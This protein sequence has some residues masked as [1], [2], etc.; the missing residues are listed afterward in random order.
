M[1]GLAVGRAA[2][3]LVLC[4]AVLLV[5]SVGGYLAAIPHAARTVIKC[6]LPLVLLL[7]TCACARFERLRPWKPVSIALLAASC[8]FLVAWVLSDR[9]LADEPTGNLDTGSGSDVMS[10]L[11]ALS[12]QGRTLVV[13]THDLHLARRA[14]RVV[15]IR[16]GVIVSDA[17]AGG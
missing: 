12:E 10:L 11:G 4:G 1:R 16:D 5:Y 9:I 14:H 2:R 13:V 6:A 8:G 3:F 7:L 15:V 17:P